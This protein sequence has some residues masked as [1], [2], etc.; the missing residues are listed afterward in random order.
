[1]SCSRLRECDEG[2]SRLRS[3]PVSGRWDGFHFKRGLELSGF[4]HRALAGR[5]QSAT[6]VG[7]PSRV[8]PQSRI[9]ATRSAEIDEGAYL[10]LL[11][12]FELRLNGVPI[13]LPLGAQRLIAFLALHN[14][15]LQRGFVAGNLWLESSEERAGANLRSALWRLHRH[16]REFVHSRAGRLS[17]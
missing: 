10:S 2:P 11:E 12:G 5:R 15:P 7:T 1:M 8:R 14:R 9:P 17:L 3:A 4:D 13:E 6:I 16:G